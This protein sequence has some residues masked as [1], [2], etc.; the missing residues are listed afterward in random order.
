MDIQEPT[1]GDELPNDTRTLSE[2][3]AKFTEEEVF[4]CQHQPW[5]ESCGY[6]LRPRYRL[7]WV[8][9]WYGTDKNP[10]HCE[11]GHALNSVCPRVSCFTFFSHIN[12]IQERVVDA[13]RI[14]DNQP[15][16]LK[17]IW[18]SRFPHEISIG[19]YFSSPELASDPQN[20]C[21]PLLDVLK[22]PD[23][24]GLQLLVMPLL[25]DFNLPSFTTVGEAVSLFKQIF[26]VRFVHFGYQ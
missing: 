20:H 3:Y 7:G 16:L 6:M 15:V 11:D 8:P 5:L 1:I 21:V 22:I 17:K 19:L 2:Y 24:E 10:R 4:W 18:M 12:E 26:E 23:A 13:V 9:S 25:R 14:F